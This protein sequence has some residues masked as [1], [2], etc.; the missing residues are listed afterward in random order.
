MLEEVK[1]DEIIFSRI[2]KIQELLEKYQ[3]SETMNLREQFIS[4]IEELI[5]DI[6]K[7][8]IGQD[9]TKIIVYENNRTTIKTTIQH[10]D[11]EISIELLSNATEDYIQVTYKDVVFEKEQVIT[12]KKENEE[13]SAILK[14][15]EEG[16][17]VEYSLVIN[18]KIEGNNCTKEI[19]AKYE[20]DSNRVEATIEQKINIQKI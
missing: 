7:N 15:I 4:E 17:T 1:Q 10:P 2:D 5:T 13:T 18:E 16:K 6:T 14:H 11:Y 9:E 3:P 19:V 20:D 8:N 12:Y